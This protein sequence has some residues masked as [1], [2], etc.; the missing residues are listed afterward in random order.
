MSG[1]SPRI[2]FDFDLVGPDSAWCQPSC[3]PVEVG[4][5]T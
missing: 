4:G 5:V 3:S 1:V 2:L